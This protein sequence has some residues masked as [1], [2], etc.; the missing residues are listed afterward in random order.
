MSVTPKVKKWS[1]DLTL[2]ESD[3]GYESASISCPLG[4]RKVATMEK[5][6]KSQASKQFSTELTPKEKQR[7]AVIVKKKS[8]MAMGLATSPGRSIMMN[9]FMMYMS[10]SNLNMWTISTIGMAIMSPIKSLFGINRQFMKFEDS[11]GKVDLQMPKIIFAVLNLVWLC[12]GLYKMGKMRLLPTYASDWS[13][14]IV[15][16]EMMEIS[17]IPP[18]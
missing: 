6:C 9:A 17:S 12:L 13:G 7:A 14:R 3:V 2:N 5:Q 15:W 11:D 4:M 1:V 8:Q 10:G 18:L 16:K